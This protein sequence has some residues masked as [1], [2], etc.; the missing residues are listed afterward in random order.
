VKYARWRALN[1]RWQV[2]LATT[3]ENTTQQTVYHGDWRYQ[4]LV[5]AQRPFKVTCFSPNSDTVDPGLVDDALVGFDVACKP[6][7]YMELVLES[8]RISITPPSL[9]PG[10]C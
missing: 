9:E 1:G 10:S 4:Y 5:V 2:I 7:G 8:G 6:T 3:M